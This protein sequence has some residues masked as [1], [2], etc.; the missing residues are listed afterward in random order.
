MMLAALALAGPLLVD[1]RPMVLRGGPAPAAA[2]V[3]PLA[4]T[5]APLRFV[6]GARPEG[7]IWSG[8][9]QVET[10]PVRLRGAPPAPPPAPAASPELPQ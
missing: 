10:A 2:L 4:V 1:A 6:G 9:V 8:A 7:A 3:E 5:T